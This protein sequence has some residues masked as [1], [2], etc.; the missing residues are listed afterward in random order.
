M[1]QEMLPI[2]ITAIG[3]DL[4]GSSRNLVEVP[5]CNLPSGTEETRKASLPVE[6][7]TQH[8]KITYL[9]PSYSVGASK[10]NICCLGCVFA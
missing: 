7:R 1:K 3:N 2:G 8:I 4:H 6:I 5:A 9:E 10:L